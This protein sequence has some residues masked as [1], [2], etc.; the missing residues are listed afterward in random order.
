MKSRIIVL[1]RKVKSKGAKK[2]VVC[3]ICGKQFKR[4]T[5]IVTYDVGL[6]NNPEVNN[7]IRKAH[8]ECLKQNLENVLHVVNN[9]CG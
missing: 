6:G 1:S 3:S 8:I 7:D 5:Y 2:N 9:V 4:G